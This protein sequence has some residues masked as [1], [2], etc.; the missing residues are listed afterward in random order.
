MRFERF[1]PSKYQF[2]EK[3][4]KFVEDFKKKIE[5]IKEKIKEI[6]SREKEEIAEILERVNEN[7][8]RTTLVGGVALRIWLDIKGKKVP[9]MYGKDFDF[10]LPK[11]IFEKVKLDLLPEKCQEFSVSQPKESFSSEIVHKLRK[12]FRIKE[13]EQTPFGFFDFLK[14]PENYFALEDR[15]KFAHLDFF[16]EKK[17][18][19]K[20]TIIYRGKKVTLLSPEELFIK[21][22]SK[23][24]KLKEEIQKRDVIYFYLNAEIIDEEKMDEIVR[25]KIFKE[26]GK[27]I[28]Q[29][30]S[31]KIWKEELG[32][33]HKKI[34]KAEK[35]GK[36]LEKVEH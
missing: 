11:E 30:M 17:E 14:T 25:R 24:R 18:D 26:K 13:K 21:R 32:K 22:I 27:E 19:Q 36:I 7:I 15:K 4:S 20:E 1:S 33:I 12:V 34:K 9:E 6:S 8:P 23:L 5:E 3:E 16:L 2:K 31:R 10:V 28:D 29:K 35:E